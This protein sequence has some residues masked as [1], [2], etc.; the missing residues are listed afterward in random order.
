MG[1]FAD[2]LPILDVG[3]A[4]IVGDACLLPSRV[5]IDLPTTMPLS[6][7]VDFWTKWGANANCNGVD[8]ALKALRRQQK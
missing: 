1:G 3:E 7:T 6:A 8:D 4:I 5:R 2:A